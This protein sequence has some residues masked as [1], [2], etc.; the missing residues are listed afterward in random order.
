M[1]RAKRFDALFV[2]AILQTFLIITS[3]EVAY[4]K[5][6]H[7]MRLDTTFSFDMIDSVCVLG[8][9]DT[10]PKTVQLFN[11]ESIR[12][13]VAQALNM[14]GFS[15]AANCGFT[16]G[17]NERDKGRPR[18][19]LTVNVDALWVSGAELTGSLIDEE[20]QREVWRDTVITG[21]GARYRNALTVQMAG[22]VGVEQ[23]IRSAL[24]K[25]FD[26]FGNRKKH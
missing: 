25:L 7:P 4:A 6:Q 20:S 19:V 22:Q 14:R 8:V 26:T 9:Y 3:S 13:D 1:Y 16:A 21:Y 11:L 18:W 23:L 10:R 5:Q 15:A 2:S 17:T 12:T 24:P